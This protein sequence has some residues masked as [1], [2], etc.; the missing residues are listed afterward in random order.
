[1]KKSY[2]ETKEF[3]FNQ[4]LRNV[5]ID[6]IADSSLLDS[7]EKLIRTIHVISEKIYKG[8]PLD[9][10]DICFC[11]KFNIKK[12]SSGWF[13][14][15]NEFITGKFINADSILGKG[16]CQKYECHKMSYNFALYSNYEE[17]RLNSGT[18]QPYNNGEEFLH[19]ICTFK[20]N[21]KE[22]VLDS[23]KFL[24]MDKESYYKL[25]RF[26]EIQSLSKKEIQKDRLLIAQDLIG[27]G[28]AKTDKSYKLSTD[29]KNIS[30]R[31]KGMGFVIYL[32]N[33]EAFINNPKPINE[34]EKENCLTRLKLLKKIQEIQEEKNIDNF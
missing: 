30:K 17:V 5:F 10:D 14:V 27:K 24:I 32:Y 28:I 15:E 33:R 26:K 21:E 23:A 22:Y 20:A 25:F 29:N 3:I 9:K 19:S 13:V 16:F 12:T 11:N 1:M 6:E 8:A 34:L 2:E 4:L 31:F 7:R 18:I